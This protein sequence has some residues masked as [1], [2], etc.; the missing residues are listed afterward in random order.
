MRRRTLVAGLMIA[1]LFAPVAS[2][3]PPTIET[4]QFEFSLEIGCG[5]FVLVEE[6]SFRVRTTTFYGADDE[7][8][9]VQAQV[10]FMG[11]I[12]APDGT[13]IRDIGHFTETHDLTERSVRFV[14]IAFNYVVPGHGGVAQ[15]RGFLL[16]EPDGDVV[17]HGPHEI[18][19]SPSQDVA[20][21]LCPLF[22]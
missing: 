18:L 15:D 21:F 22:T 9:R 6:L 8:T 10:G 16:I 4:Q 12:T 2:A 13:A 3:A 19:A 5:T 7:P 11:I 17:I 14:G 20:E 1:A